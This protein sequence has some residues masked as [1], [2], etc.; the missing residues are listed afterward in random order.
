[1]EYCLIYRGDVVHNP[2]ICV[3][4][5]FVIVALMTDA[6]TTQTQGSTTVVLRGRRKRSP[7]RLTSSILE[8]EM[9]EGDQVKAILKVLSS[10]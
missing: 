6:S 9:G 7:T 5:G 8:G 3:K 10:H 2:S 4:I 1:M